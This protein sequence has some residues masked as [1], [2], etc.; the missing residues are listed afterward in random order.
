[1][2]PFN[3]LGYNKETK[4][5]LNNIR[6]SRCPTY[7]GETLHLVVDLPNELSISYGETTRV[8]KMGCVDHG[9]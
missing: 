2:D 9:N 1:M 8:K 7:D 6:S 5:T 3:H 4:V